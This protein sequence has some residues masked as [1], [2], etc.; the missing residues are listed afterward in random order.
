MENR[1]KERLRACVTTPEWLKSLKVRQIF[2]Q[3]YFLMGKKLGR[4]KKG[5]EVLTAQAKYIKEVFYPRIKIDLSV[6]ATR[7]AFPVLST[8]SNPRCSSFTNWC[9]LSLKSSGWEL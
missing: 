7:L 3:F 4:K 9:V 8:W 6:P 1:K 5:K 2:G